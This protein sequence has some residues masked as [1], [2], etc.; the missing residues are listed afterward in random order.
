MYSNEDWL[1]SFGTGNLEPDLEIRSSHLV[2]QELHVFQG[3]AEM[4]F[5]AGKR[6]SLPDFLNLERSDC[7]LLQVRH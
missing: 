6:E 2:Q 5:N 1:T 7:H 4:S 3:P